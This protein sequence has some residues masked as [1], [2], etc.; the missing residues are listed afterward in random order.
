MKFPTHGLY[1]ITQTEHKS[2][3]TIIAEVEQV[4]LGGAV[5][6]QYRNKQPQNA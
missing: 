3:D 1:A 6:I 2:T 5:V 4:I